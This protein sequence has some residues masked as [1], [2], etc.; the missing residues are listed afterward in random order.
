[1]LRKKHAKRRAALIL[2]KHAVRGAT[3]RAP[4]DQ[5]LCQRAACGHSNAGP[6]LSPSLRKIVAAGQN[7]VKAA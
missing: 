1:M 7:P 4:H 6:V 5:A 2:L 3:R